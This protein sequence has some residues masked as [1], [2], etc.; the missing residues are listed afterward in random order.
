MI[1]SQDP[2]LYSLG[3][4]LQALISGDMEV[5][6]NILETITR[7]AVIP[8]KRGSIPIQTQAVVFARDKYR[9]SYCARETVCPPALR[10]VSYYFPALVPYHPHGK[11][12]KTHPLYWE[13]YA[14]CDHI[15]P[16]ARGGTSS[17]DNLATSCYKCNTIKSSWLLSE[18]RWTRRAVPDSEWDGFSGL[19]IQTMESKPI[20]AQYFRTWQ[21]ALLGT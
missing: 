13:A 10:Y 6:G 20:R 19:F 14:S 18:L 11:W 5:A 4:G 16:V 3:K 9:C 8:D 12:D 17:L 21:L 2:E 15:V 7:P 1:E